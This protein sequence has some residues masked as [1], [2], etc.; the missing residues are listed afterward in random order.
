MDTY[1]KELARFLSYGQ[2]AVGLASQHL[3][4]HWGDCRQVEKK[5]SH[6]SV[7]TKEDIQSEEII[8]E[9]LEKVVPGHS[10]I[11]EE[12][13]RTLRD[14]EFVW[15]FDPL[16]GSSYY[17]RGLQSFSVSLALLCEWQPVLGIVAC[18]ANGEV[19]T[20]VRG[21]GSF[22]NAKQISTSSVCELRDC[23]LSFSHRFLRAPEYLKPRT[24]LVPSCRSIRGGGS[25]A[26]ELCYIACGRIDGFIAPAQSLWDFAAGSLILTEAGGHFS[27]F[28]GES[29]EY[30]RMSQK[31]FAIVGSNGTVHRIILAE[32]CSSFQKDQASRHN[33]QP[34][35]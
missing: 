32:L 24:E 9:F 14:S 1:K 25:C 8:V 16:D 18:P 33:A 6:H 4:A 29:P 17:I 3:L 28:A 19:F 27:G 31:D 7:V 11:S 34:V 15:V 30:L 35:Q 22:L 23:I 12:R 5:E 26:Q 10:L 13:G 2:E 21:G 20:A